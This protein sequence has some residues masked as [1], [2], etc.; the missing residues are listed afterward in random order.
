MYQTALILL[1]VILFGVNTPLL[2][3]AEAEYEDFYVGVGGSYAIEN[4]SG[5]LDPDNS[6]GFNAK[7]GY[8]LHELIA[9]QFD[10]DYL[11]GF[12]DKQKVSVSGTTYKGKYEVDI[13]TFILSLKG[14]FP[15]NPYNIR[16]FV[17]AGVG[18]M[19]ADADTKFTASGPGTSLRIHETG[20]HTDWCIKLGGGLDWYLNRNLSLGLEGSYV[21]GLGDLNDF[22][23]FNI[24]AGVAYH[25]GSSS[26]LARQLRPT[27]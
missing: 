19:Y 10:Y 26:E 8:R 9:L 27:P 12:D 7:A 22:Q 14:Y 3:A 5:G 11:F 24:G 4:F 18:G 15:I 21:W 20:D 2:H 17:I 1:T 25:F 13:Q 6:W 23:Y 16:P